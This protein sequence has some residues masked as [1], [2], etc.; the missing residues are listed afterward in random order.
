MDEHLHN[1]PLE[2]FFRRSLDDF[3]DE[4]SDDVWNGLD[5][6]LALH[7][8]GGEG[9]S[10]SA[11][12]PTGGILT[13]SSFLKWI[14]MA[15]IA[16]LLSL[17]TYYIYQQNNEIANLSQH[18]NQ[19]TQTI[20]ELHTKVDNLE[21]NEEEELQKGKN[22]PSANSLQNN[23]VEPKENIEKSNTAASKNELNARN[24]PPKSSSFNPLQNNNLEQNKVET[25]EGEDIA[26]KKEVNQSSFNPLQNN[27]LEQNKVETIEGEDIAAKKEVNQSSF[28]PLSNSNLEQNKVETIEVGDIAAKK[29]VNQSS[30]N[31]LQNNNLE[32]NKVET[33]EGNGIAAKKEL[34]K[35]SM[36]PLQNKDLHQ[37]TTEDID[38]PTTSMEEDAT[39]M[40]RTDETKTE[41][42][43]QSNELMESLD[44]LQKKKTQKTLKVKPDKKKAAKLE[45][46]LAQKSSKSTKSTDNSVEEM[47]NQSLPQTPSASDSQW[48]IA[49]TFA[50]ARSFRTIKSTIPN[51]N[52][53]KKINEQEKPQLSFETGIEVAY[54]FKTNWHL[55]SGVNYR[56][57]NQVAVYKPKLQYRPDAPK[58]VHNGKPRFIYNYSIPGSYGLNEVE[59]GL[60]DFN[61]ITDGESFDLEV[62]NDQTFNWMRVPLL[63]QH[64]LGKGRLQ[65]NIMGGLAANFLLKEK[66]N[67]NTVK[68]MDNRFR[69]HDTRP[70]KP[71]PQEKITN[72][73]FEYVL[74]VG[75]SYQINDHLQLFVTPTYSAAL[76]PVYKNKVLKTY[77]FS[78][79]GNIGV[80]LSL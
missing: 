60:E 67:F 57:V 51:D 45:N 32:Q 39:K 66:Q 5:N 50:P 58:E 18:I 74:G 78:L 71:L 22:L 63:V 13:A 23:N 41:T 75:L 31:P 76:A 47:D 68:S 52:M 56:Q 9:V 19:Q 80:R 17:A 38:F 79:S 12:P 42:D 30:F 15:A 64:D 29:E 10:P 2:E 1:D 55:K 6:R 73:Y 25:I 33:I 48:A 4:P 26:A 11:T 72:S 54:Q 53:V 43:N 37:Y 8:S 40:D 36:T 20:E 28:N 49:A 46:A 35:T 3:G 65:G 34:D 77:P 24:L 62:K 16:G 69:H 61:N 44:K 7:E 59:F 14:G 27:N 21:T 70:N